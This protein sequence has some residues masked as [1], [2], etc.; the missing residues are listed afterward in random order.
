[1]RAL[2]VAA[3]FA[4]C[5]SG[6]PPARTGGGGAQAAE[7]RPGPPRSRV[8]ADAA[9][10][11]PPPRVPGA[12][13]R[14]ADAEPPFEID[15]TEVTVGDYA[16]CV[17]AGACEAAQ[18]WEGYFGMT[19]GRYAKR[20]HGDKTGRD[21]HPINCVTWYQA[22]AYCA[23]KGK[24]LPT[25]P[26]WTAAARTSDGGSHAWKDPG[27]P[28]L[29]C[30]LDVGR[31]HPIMTCPVGSKPAGATAAGALDMGG[32]VHE[33]TATDGD[34]TDQLTGDPFKIMRGGSA[35]FPDLVFRNKAG[36]SNYFHHLGFRC[37][38]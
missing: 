27:T 34:Y 3:L 38:R 16:E 10:P 4:A 6:G 22:V 29:E 2:V 14:V 31:S 17:A 9:P 12:M 15:V 8:V 20:C 18:G 25:E 24:R 13:V 1:M 7:E 11:P 19:D 23:W 5:S 35:E 30:Q 37:A 36:P 32:N 33:W 26:E 28:D 21:E